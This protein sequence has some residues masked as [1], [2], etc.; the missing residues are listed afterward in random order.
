[1]KKRLT[2]TYRYVNQVP[3]RDTDDVRIPRQTGHRFQANLDSDSTANWT[4]IPEQTGQSVIA[5]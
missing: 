3:L 5:A 4:L 2:D 1:G